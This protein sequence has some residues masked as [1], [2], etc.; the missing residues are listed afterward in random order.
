MFAVVASVMLVVGVYAVP[1]VS[2]LLADG[3]A[4]SPPALS[5]PE[6]SVQAGHSSPRPTGHTYVVR[7]GDTLR[8]IALTAYGNEARWRAIYRANRAAIR[9]P[10]ALVVGTNL[11]IP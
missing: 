4:P 10:D 1:V 3:G 6:G 8:S 11:T 2:R 5:T 9:D 7:A